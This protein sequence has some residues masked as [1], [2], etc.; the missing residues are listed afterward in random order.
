MIA[1]FL[2]VLP[3]LFIATN[4]IRVKTSHCQYLLVHVSRISAGAT[5][6]PQQIVVRD[7]RKCN[8]QDSLRISQRGSRR[9]VT[10]V[11]CRHSAQYVGISTWPETS[12][13]TLLILNGGGFCARLE[14]IPQ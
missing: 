2:Q 13:V 10:M 11:F 4:K 5:H 6:M 8:D 12:R 14:D 9:I 7:H 3:T 1:K